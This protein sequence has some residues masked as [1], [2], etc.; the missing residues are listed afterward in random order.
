MPESDVAGL[1]GDPVAGETI[2]TAAGCASCHMAP[3]AEGEAQR[4]LS[5]GQKFPSDF[6]TF[7]AP[8][9]SPDPDH[10]IGGWDLADLAGAL[11][12]GVSPEGEHYYP[13]FPYTAYTHMELQDIAD[14]KAYLDTLPASDAPSQPHQV[15]FPFNIRRAMF[16]WNLLYLS[17]H[18]VLP[19]GDDPKLERGRYLVEA[20]AHCGECHTP[21][22][23]LGGMDTDRWMAGAPDPS[24]KGKVPNI[25]PAA[26]DWGESDIVFFLETGFTPNFD[27]AGGH[28][29]DVI[30][31]MAKLSAED[32]AAVAAY[33]A[34]LPP[35]ASA[36]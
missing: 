4:V 5:G 36:P 16:G 3:G 27:A 17:D 12:R 29:V 13:A 25:T 26:L 7:I 23:A 18:W 14:L 22:T 32:R 15:G 30:N 20:L 34:A 21:R 28:M 6:G 2:F 19:V 8:N 31:N 33:I 11:T 9:I 1:T 24:G 10:G 35:V